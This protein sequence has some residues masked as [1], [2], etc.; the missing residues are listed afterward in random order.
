MPTQVLIENKDRLSVTCQLS[1]DDIGNPKVNHYVWRNINSS[2]SRDTGSNNKLVL[3]SVNAKQHDG[4]WQCQPENSVG[5]GQLTQF[6]VT[7][8]GECTNIVI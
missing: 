7:V 5:Q 2:Y 6:K 3:S 4:I 1:G 8:N